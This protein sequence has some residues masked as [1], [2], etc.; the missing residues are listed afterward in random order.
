MLGAMPGWRTLAAFLPPDLQ[1]DPLLRRS[2]LASTF[3]AS[4]EMCK[5]GKLRIRQDGTFG[6]IYLRSAADD[7]QEQV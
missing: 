1:G 2:A 3:A 6:P 4:L 7:Q 5:E